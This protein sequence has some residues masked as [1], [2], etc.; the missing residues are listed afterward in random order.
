MRPLLRG[1]IFAREHAAPG[2]SC[3]RSN[4]VGRDAPPEIA[5][6]ALTCGRDGHDDDTSGDGPSGHN[7]RGD[8]PR[9]IPDHHRRRSRHIPEAP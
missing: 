8:D 4:R 5:L 9:N 1:S 7:S 2:R 3:L 6:M